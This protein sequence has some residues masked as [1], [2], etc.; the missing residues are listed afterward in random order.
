[1]TV[2]LLSM[3]ADD[4]GYAAGL[5]TLASQLVQIGAALAQRA[6]EL[7]GNQLD[8]PELVQLEEL[9]RQIDNR[10]ERSEP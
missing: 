8:P 7:D 3:Q 4:A 1:M 5:R 10:T 9:T 6:G 2:E